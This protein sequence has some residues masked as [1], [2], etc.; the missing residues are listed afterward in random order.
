[1]RISQPWRFINIFLA[2]FISGTGC[3]GAWWQFTPTPYDDEPESSL[4]AALLGYLI[5]GSLF[6]GTIVGLTILGIRYGG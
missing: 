2:G 1:M 4:T 3:F 6:I 5:G